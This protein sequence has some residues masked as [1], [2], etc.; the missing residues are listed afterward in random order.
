MVGREVRRPQVAP[1]TGIIST[2]EPL[3]SAGSVLVMQLTAQHQAPSD[4]GSLQCRSFG[5]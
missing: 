5:R 2:L 4:I 3:G 1:D